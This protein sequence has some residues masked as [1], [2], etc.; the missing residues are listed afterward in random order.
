VEP[1][2]DPLYPLILDSIHEGVFTV[3]REFRVTSFNA[4]AERITGLPRADAI[5]R[6]C[7]EVFRASCCQGG[8]ALRRTLET[9]KP[10][11]QVRIDVLD[12]RMELV[13]ISVSTAVLR[14]RHGRL[15]GGVE[16][17][18]DV[19]DL[20]ALRDELAGP[21]GGQELIGESAAIRELLATL[22]DVAAADASVLV[23]GPSGSGKELVARA[24]HRLS[25]RAARPFVQVNC[26]A[27][28]DTLLESELFGHVRGA[29]TDARRDKPG[30]FTLAHRGTLFLDEIG[31]LSPAFQVKLLRVLEDGEVHPLGATAG[32]KVDVRIVAATNRDLARRVHD[33]QFRE[34]LYYRLRVVE[35]R[36]PSLA[37]RRVDIPL[38]AEH[39]LRRAAVRTGK[40][41][42]GL[43]PAAL[44]ALQA[45]AFPGNVRELRNVIERAFVF[46][47]G[48]TIEAA[49]LPPEVHGEAVRRPA[50]RAPEALAVVPPSG[51]DATSLLPG[52][53]VD[54]ERVLAALERHRWSRTR[55][56]HELKIG[57]NTLWR[58]MR[59]LG[60]S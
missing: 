7:H 54:A 23:T 15:L 6:R 49:H 41:V 51:G 2:I 18:R 60:L 29:F 10:L 32:R 48:A 53:R 56:A 8:C 1:R 47:R 26:G 58:W 42:E 20:E 46:C 14:D 12:A 59:R 19:S 4:E 28:P 25:S 9:G 55:A 57:R 21:A 3:D 30:R 17:F 11:R 38:L 34:D 33:G 45:Y 40:P 43:S 5:G 24:L 52:R 16:I 44:R 13:P 36:L 39:F 27:L 35:L 31:D 22:P 50:G 37:E